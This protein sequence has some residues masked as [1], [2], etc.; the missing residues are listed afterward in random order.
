M[1]W[2]VYNDPAWC[3]KFVICI[4][5]KVKV[6]LILL[7]FVAYVA[8]GK[9]VKFQL[10]VSKNNDV[11]CSQASRLRSPSINSDSIWQTLWHILT[12]SKLKSFPTRQCVDPQRGFPTGAV[13]KSLPADAEEA[14]DT[15]SAP[16]LGRSPRGGNCN[17]LSIL[18]WG[19]PW[20][21]DPSGL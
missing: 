3:E 8:I 4:S 2:D 16:R 10:E 19:L 5:D 14:R 21:E 9:R 6:V 7:C 11:I 20:T 15:G 17:P 18:A 13:V 12:D 1:C